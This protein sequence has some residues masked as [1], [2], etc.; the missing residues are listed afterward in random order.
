L[1]GYVSTWNIGRC[2][3]RGLKIYGGIEQNEY[4]DSNL[5]FGRM[6]FIQGAHLVALELVYKQA[7][8]KHIM[9]LSIENPVPISLVGAGFLIE[10]HWENRI[11]CKVFVMNAIETE[12]ICFYASKG[13]NTSGINQGIQ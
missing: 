2:F 3:I 8:L 6:P 10:G 11:I 1:K 9:L 13:M 12:F 7:S 4:A 5:D